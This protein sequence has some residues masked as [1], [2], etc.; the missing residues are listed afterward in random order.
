MMCA[1]SGFEG[2]MLFGDGV[3]QLVDEERD[4]LSGALSGDVSC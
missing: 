1:F 3:V 2:V 4:S